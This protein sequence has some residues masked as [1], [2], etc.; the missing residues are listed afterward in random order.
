MR[1]VIVCG[2][3]GV[4]KTTVAETIAGRVDAKLLRTDVIRKELLSDPQYT[5]E[6]TEMVYDEMLDRSRRTIEGGR[7]VV[8]DGTFFKRE[9]RQRAREMADEIGAE[10]DVVRVR[11]DE[12]VVR[13]RIRQRENGASD[14]DFEVY[15]IHKDIFEPLDRDH[16]TVDNSEGL[17]ETREQ[18]RA[19][20]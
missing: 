11:C 19:H 5:D 18:V 15:R 1:L 14:A 8:C 6:E 13:E 20:F 3:P 2:F 17:A 9:F 7:N 12:E 4:G 10:I 16:Y